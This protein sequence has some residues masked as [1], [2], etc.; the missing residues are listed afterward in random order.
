[1][2]LF[3]Q[4]SKT[5]LTRRSTGLTKILELTESS[6]YPNHV[7]IQFTMG[8]QNCPLQA[9]KE[10]VKAVKK[11]GAFLYF[12]YIVNKDLIIKNSYSKLICMFLS[13]GL[14]HIKYI[15]LKYC[16]IQNRLFVKRHSDLYKITL[17]YSYFLSE[18]HSIIR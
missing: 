11:T 7:Y 18:W 12:Q 3:N 15:S 5:S 8:K 4:Y 10:G 14:M 9:Y 13:Y 2:H 17:S 16:K 6:S 1:M